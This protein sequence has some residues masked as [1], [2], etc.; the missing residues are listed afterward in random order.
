M[1]I[2]QNPHLDREILIIEKIVLN[3]KK[4]QRLARGSDIT[5]Q[6]NESMF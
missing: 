2:G 1:Q 6:Q 5:S 3:N 4:K